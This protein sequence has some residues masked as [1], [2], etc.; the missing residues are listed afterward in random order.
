MSSQSVLEI[1]LAAIDHNM[2]VLR[3]MVGDECA[4][5]PIV[6]ADAYG[7]GAR[8]VGRRLEASGASMLAV[9]TPDQAADLFAGAIGLPVL[10]LMPVSEIDRVG[11]LYRA[12]VCERL[13]LTVHGPRQAGELVGLAE[14]FGTRIP[15]HLEVDTGMCRAGCALDEAPTLLRRLLDEPRL[16]LRGLFTHFASSNRDDPRTDEQLARFDQLLEGYADLLPAD[17]IV[18]AANTCATI[19]HSRFHKSMVRVGMAWAGF[20]AELAEG[21]VSP[22]AE[23]LRPVVRWCS[24]LIHLKRVAPGERVGYGQ[25]WTARRKSLIGLVPAGYAD[26]YPPALGGTDAQR[27]RGQVSVL[28]SVKD[29]DRG[30]APVIGAVNMDQITVDLTSLERAGADLRVGMPVELL[31]VAPE[32]PN[33]LTELAATARML[34]HALLCGLSPTVPRDYVEGVPQPLV[35][36]VVTGGACHAAPDAGGDRERLE[37]GAVAMAPAR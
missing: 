4:I 14:R 24:R 37:N 22:D 15:V 34:P 30:Y 16:V 29:R 20:G 17:C 28:T 32:A 21:R 35:E 7:L 3:D 27:R 5:C 36:T 31:S 2:R 10:V 23:R 12:L 8:R 25:S 19:R 9:Y 33:C 13:H 6:K 11:E 26:G 1:N 18:H